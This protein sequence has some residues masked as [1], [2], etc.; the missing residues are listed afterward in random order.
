MSTSLVTPAWDCFDGHPV[1]SALWRTPAR[2]AAVYAGR[3]SGKTAISRR[4]VVRWLPVRKP[5]PDPMYFYAMPTYGQARR[6]AWEPIKALVPKAWIAPDGIKESSMVIRT[7][8]GSTLHVLGMDKPQRF[9]GNQWD[10]GVVDESCDHK[11]RMF[12]RTM[13]PA[14]SHRGAWCWRIGVPKR[15]GSSAKEFKDFCHLGHEPN[16]LRLMS[17]TWSS[18]DVLT[19]EEIALARSM[20]DPKDYNEQYRACWE[21]VGGLVFYAFSEVLNVD[22]SVCYS[23]KLPLLIGSDF[24]VDPMAWVVAQ[25]RGGELHVIDELFMRNANTQAALDELARRYRGHAAGYNFYGD[26]TGRNRHSSASVSDYVQV[27][28]DPRFA[29]S[30]VFYPVSNPARADRFAACNAVLCS[31]SGV[32]RCKVHPRCE[33]LVEDLTSRAYEPGTSEPDDHDD[34]GHV[35]DAWGYMV[36]AL[37]PLAVRFTDSTPEVIAT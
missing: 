1:Q 8:F 16:D 15:T 32:R 19:P 5:W 23:P 27:K 17:Y 30:R 29:P 26:A 9:E 36:H 3:G 20:L 14:F 24:N 25:H 31:A 6:V 12:D 21:T 28:N 34:V 10:G 13:M 4:R 7:V 11:P 33:H 35:T 22:D 2:F 37:F 18:E